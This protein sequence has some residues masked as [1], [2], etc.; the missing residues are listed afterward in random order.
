MA[1]PMHKKTTRAE[2]LNNLTFRTLYNQYKN[3]ALNVFQWEGLPEGIQER[4]I[5]QILFEEGKILFFRDPAMSYMAL[6]CFPGVNLD[7]YN[8]PL[9]WRAMGL[10]YSKEFDR[11]KCVLIENNKLRTPTEDGV[12]FYVNKLYEAER[13]QDTN[14]RTSKMPWIAVCDEKNLLTYK[15][16][17]RKVDANEPAIFAAKGFNPDAIQILPTKAT[18]MGNELIDYS[19]SVQNDLLTFL[20]V[21]NCP[22]DKKERLVAGE[23]TSN[24]D[25]VQTNAELLLEARQRACDAINEMFPDLHV[26]VKLRHEPQEVKPDDSVPGKGDGGNP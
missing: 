12:L 22:V 6:P 9:R 16:V 15:E 20:G 18:F 19:H 24:D 4:Y 2:R 11:D 23:V 25:L 1:K 26:S 10:G 13:T 3:M 7:V 21:N 5:E 14:V 17:I 8:E